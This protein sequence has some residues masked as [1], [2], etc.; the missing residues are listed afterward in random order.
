MTKKLK[1][2]KNY[3][4]TLE[5]VTE[6]FLATPRDSQRNWLLNRSLR[7]LGDELD[8]LDSRAPDF[9]AG[10]EPTDLMDRESAK[11]SDAEIMEDWQIPVMEAMAATICTPQADILEI[12]FG[13]GVASDFIQA[14]AVNSHTIIECNPSVLEACHG[15]RAD[16]PGQTIHIVEG[17]WQDT[18]PSLPQFDGIFFHTYPLSPEEYVA[19]VAKSATFAEHFFEPAA[20]HLVAGGALAYLTNEADSLSRAHQRALLKHF[21]SVQLSRLDA[22]PIKSDTRDSQWLDSMIIARATK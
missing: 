15:W 11:L 1:R 7:E 2:T 9:V 5:I 12:G 16:R 21:S 18:I 14:H 22:L 20:Q 6:G 17:L 19:T 8:Y 4:A 3:V 13:R 10:G